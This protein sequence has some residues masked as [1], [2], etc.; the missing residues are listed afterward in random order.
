MVK[1]FAIA[2]PKAIF[3]SEQ[4]R[5]N[6]YVQLFSSQQGQRVLLDLMSVAGIGRLSYNKENS[7]QTDF[8]EGKKFLIYHI[9]NLMDAHLQPQQQEGLY[10]DGR[11][12]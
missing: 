1:K 5:Q 7:R 6:D 10:D 8:N 11:N 3:Q 2:P 12:E 9:H 4:H